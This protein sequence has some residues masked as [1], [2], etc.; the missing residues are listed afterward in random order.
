MTQG[1]TNGDDNTAKEEREFF[2]LFPELSE[3]DVL[4]LYAE[5]S[6]KTL[7]CPAHA[8][9]RRCAGVDPR[10]ER[11]F[12]SVA[13]AVTRDFP[14]TAYLS[15]FNVSGTSLDA[16]KCQFA[17]D[18]GKATFG[19]FTYNPIKLRKNQ[20]H[21]LVDCAKGAVKRFF[22]SCEGNSCD[23]INAG[24]T[25]TDVLA[26]ESAESTE[27]QL[28]T[29]DA[30]TM[31]VAFFIFY[32]MVRSW[33][34]LLLCIWNMTVTVAS[35]FGALSLLVRM[36]HI[37]PMSIQATFAQALAV[38][39]S[40]DYSLFLL[41]RFRDENKNGHSIEDA[42]RIMLAQAG[43]V[44]VLS[45]GTFI[46]VFVGFLFLPSHDLMALGEVAVV[47]LFFAL[48]V[49]LTN[50]VAA[51]HVFPNFFSKFTFTTKNATSVTGDAEAS[52]QTES[53]VEVPLLRPTATGKPR[54]R[55]GAPYKGWYLTFLRTATTFPYNIAFIVIVY[56]MFIPLAIQSF[57]IKHNQNAVQITPQSAQGAKIY[58]DL[59][60]NFPPGLLG[61]FKLVVTSESVKATSKEFFE[62]TQTVVEGVSTG[63]DVPENAFLSP[64]TLN[65]KRISFAE[66]VELR[67][68]KSIL[69]R[70]LGG[71]ADLCA[72]Y[73]YVWKQ[74]INAEASA[75][76]T[77]VQVPFNP[78]SRLGI[79]FVLVAR[80]AI[81]DLMEKNPKFK[82]LLTGNEVDFYEDMDMAFRSMP[83]L[84]AST[85]LVVFILLGVG[86]RSAFIPIRLSLT[87]FVP[88]ATVFG[89]GVLI[90]QDG[91][92]K[93]WH[94]SAFMPTDD[95]FFWFI[96]L[97]C[98]FQA[99]GLVLDYGECCGRLKESAK[100]TLNRHFPRP[101]SPGAPC[102]RI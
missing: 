2:R 15:Y 54:F 91:L 83:A 101:S 100:L 26:K 9:K 29:V 74:S 80:D 49:N 11:L 35:S 57:K 65:G 44:V 45:C 71:S 25:G 12:A 60:K 73:Q 97:V 28:F 79:D 102:V 63:T 90:Y 24:M 14:D 30:F 37:R 81:D 78:Y 53:A 84:V 20:I 61:Q 22:A 76:I 68:A 17:S 27:H 43:H 3:E 7:V 70:A 19:V 89:V 5:S 99:L 82:V 34:L 33:R 31:P 23:D 36:L 87:V 67:N 88:L 16:I 1:A 69:C 62:F 47:T 85:L 75:L 58:R 42:S 41:R 48:S 40:I 96:P 98:L 77:S 93:S 38:S 64:T 95:G 10:V 86:F 6:A 66:S 13:D 4:L 55:R 94:I 59:Q 50:T 72:L 52:A 46:L 18:D 21:K 56:A 51:L 8:C 92:L 39:M 32:V